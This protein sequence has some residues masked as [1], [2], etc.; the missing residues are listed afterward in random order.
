MEIYLKILLLYKKQCILKVQTKY[1]I[2]E[3]NFVFRNLHELNHIILKIF[4]AFQ[5]LELAIKL[6]NKFFCNFKK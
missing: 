1:N 4:Q 2:S 3:P 6:N 5:I